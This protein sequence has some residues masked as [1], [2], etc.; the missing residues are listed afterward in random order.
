[1]I[2]PGMGHAMN[3]GNTGSGTGEAPRLPS[4]NGARLTVRADAGPTIGTGHVMRGLALALG[5]L[6]AGGNAQ[7]ASHQLPDALRRRA[8]AG[9]VAVH[10]LPD[11]RETVWLDDN[12]LVAVDGWTFDEEF[13]A[14]LAA[15]RAPLLMVDDT[16]ARTWVPGAFVVNHNVYAET[17][18]YAGRTD[19][20]VLAGPRYALLR[21]EFARPVPAR[22][23]PLVARRLLLLL[24][25][26][27]PA[28]VSATVL[29]A[30]Q[31]ARE[32]EPG[33]AEI[34]LVVGAANP[35]LARLQ[36]AAGS[37][38]GIEVLHDVQDMVSLMDEA[39]MVV[40]ASGSTVLEL[41]SRG[42]P[43][44][45]GALV[46][47][48]I[49]PARR[50]DALGAAQMLGPFADLDADSLGASILGLARDPARRAAMSEIAGTLVDGHGVARVIAQ[51]APSVLAL[52]P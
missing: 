40:S 1:M 13:L 44:L 12:D 24:G 23:H 32:A 41:A 29:A 9:G 3:E 5:W 45:L 50:M 25:G 2:V 35:A 51:V 17:E 20:A 16:A 18:H 26:A 31:W 6:R 4:L 14:T 47:E 19:A 28:G 38:R 49:A 22:K 39:D 33:L 36:S 15:S 46:P 21:P 8:E 48:E 42:A 10:P 7:L 37:D 27:D 30:A 52:R 11:P 34:R 43:M